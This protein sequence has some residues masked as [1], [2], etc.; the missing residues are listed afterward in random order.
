MPIVTFCNNGSRETGNTSSAI[1]IA[2]YMSIK[3]NMKILLVSTNFN[4]PTV[5]ES[6]WETRKQGAFLDRRKSTE[7]MQSGIEG[8]NRMITSG[9]IEPRIIRDYTRVIL[10]E[11]LDVLVGFEGTITEYKELQ[12]KYAAIILEANKY[13]DMVFVDLDKRLKKE[14]KNEIINITNVYIYTTNQKV[15][16]IQKL[17]ESIEENDKID[18]RDVIILL[19]RYNQNLKINAK[20]VS[21]AIVRQRNAVNTVPYNGKFYESMQDGKVVDMFL[22]WFNL[23]NKKDPNFIFLKELEN[24]IDNILRKWEEI[25]IRKH[26]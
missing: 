3:H 18:K 24:T 13:Y 20:N 12:D 25:K 26:M 15:S 5:K 16:D 11:R 14:V 2:T 10:K 21:R 19:T 8:L 22:Q 6:Y 4:E 17:T 9:K 7:V 23:K 1:A